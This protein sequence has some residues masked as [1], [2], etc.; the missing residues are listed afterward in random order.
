MAIRG[1]GPG[2]L[3]RFQDS[4]PPRLV[5]EL[6]KV[7]SAARVDCRLYSGHS[8]RNRAATTAAMQG[9]EDSTIKMLGRWKSEAFQ[10]YLKTPREH[11]AAM[12]KILGKQN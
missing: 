2:P 8:F 6:K 12:T 5:V 9:L 11:L 7:L 10:A 4:V 3:F 1:P